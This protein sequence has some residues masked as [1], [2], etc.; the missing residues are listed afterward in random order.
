MNSFVL[1]NSQKN[2][3]NTMRKY[4]EKDEH[5]TSSKSSNKRISE[6]E[7]GN[8]NGNS[9]IK[10]SKVS[11]IVSNPKETHAKQVIKFILENNRNFK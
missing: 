8:A 7:T 10:N 2:V 1:K 4:L 6:S 3:L 5:K 9:S 11:K